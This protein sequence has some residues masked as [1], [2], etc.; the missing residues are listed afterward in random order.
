MGRVQQADG[1]VLAVDVDQPAAQLPQ[2]GGCGRHPIDA[3]SA[4]A[5][6]CDLTAQGQGIGALISGLFQAV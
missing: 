3:A 6:G 5:L 2:D 1:V 4:F